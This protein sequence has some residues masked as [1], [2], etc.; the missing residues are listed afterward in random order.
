VSFAGNR[1]STALIGKPINMALCGAGCSRSQA[2]LSAGANVK[3][4]KVTGTD[5]VL[6]N[7]V[8]RVVAQAGILPTD[9]ATG[10][11]GGTPFSQRDQ[12][13][14]AVASRPA[15]PWRPSS[16]F[17]VDLQNL[18]AGERP[19][20]LSYQ[21]KDDVRAIRIERSVQIPGGACLLFDDGPQFA[22]RYDPHAYASLA[23]DTGEAIAKFAIR[24]D[25]QSVMVHEW[26]D[27]ARP[28]LTGPSLRI[29]ANGVET[30]Q[31]LLKKLVP[32]QWYD[33]SLAAKL[34]GNAG[35]WRLTISGGNSKTEVFENLPIKSANWKQL[36]WLG[37]IADASVKAETCVGKISVGIVP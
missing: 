14:E 17:I 24:I 19:L 20:E 8:S 21:P 23:F 34:G 12:G 30:Q 29:S 4:V 32:G 5:T 36:N 6:G 15:R 1:V 2:A 22:N 16:D 27:S 3:A 10:L 28:F 31:R 9:R 25:P 33:F 7:M 26:R 11:G 18:A 35:V 13:A 37:F